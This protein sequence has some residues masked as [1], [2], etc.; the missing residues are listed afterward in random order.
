MN[1]YYM[2]G[3]MILLGLFVMT[4]LVVGEYRIKARERKQKA[5]RMALNHASRLSAEDARRKAALEAERDKLLNALDKNSQQMLS[6]KGE[7]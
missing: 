4:V 2:F 6:V 3:L 1:V 5:I 7:E